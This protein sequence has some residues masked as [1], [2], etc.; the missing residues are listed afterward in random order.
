MKI[1]FDANVYVSEALVGHGAI[2]IIEATQRGKWRIY[3]SKYLLQELERVL[4]ED[5]EFS[6]RSALLIHKRVLSRST[7]V[8]SESSA[9]VTEDPKDSP[10]L[11]AA[12]SCGADYLVSNDQ[13]LLRLDP[14]EGLRIISMNAYHDLLEDEGLLR[15]R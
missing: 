13:H 10:I 5:L 8:E 2:R 6:L 11:Q 14:F 3:S 1:F 15:L 9:E 7:L 12:L 4:V